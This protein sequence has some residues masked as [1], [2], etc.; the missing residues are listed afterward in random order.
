MT[1][2]EGK[3][4]INNLAIN[5][6]TI[7]G[8]TIDSLVEG[9]HQTFSL[10]DELQEQSRSFLERYLRK[11]AP[12]YQSASQESQKAIKDTLQSAV[13]FFHA[14]MGNTEVG[15]SDYSEK[16]IETEDELMALRIVTGPSDRGMWDDLG[17]YHVH[18]WTTA[19]R[20]SERARTYPEL[21]DEVGSDEEVIKKWGKPLTY[22]M[23]RKRPVKYRSS[24]QRWADFGRPGVKEKIPAYA[25]DRA[26]EGEIPFKSVVD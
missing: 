15:R 3:Q 11:Y 25:V 18:K 24:K 17:L 2:E 6:L 1:K 16:E 9:A 23:T 21:F 12:G 19:K 5:D 22:R 14:F 4:T 7:N 20:K 10:A 13:Y 26:A 8:L